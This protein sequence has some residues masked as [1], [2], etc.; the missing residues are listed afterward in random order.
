ML[1]V[2]ARSGSS[3]RHPLWLG[4]CIASSDVRDS[5]AYYD[6]T[7]IA[8]LYNTREFEY[9]Q[10]FIIIH[11]YHSVYKQIKSCDVGRKGV[12][13]TQSMAMWRRP[14]ASGAA[15]PVVGKGSE[16]SKNGPSNLC[17]LG[18]QSGHYGQPPLPP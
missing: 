4:N 12:K 1:T 6:E 3:Y 7:I 18:G 5:D 8:Q 2:H 17:Q 11:S 15:P 10:V 9:I 13:R 16:N 14:T